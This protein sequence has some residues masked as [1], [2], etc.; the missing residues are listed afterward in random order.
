MHTVSEKESQTSGHFGPIKC[1][2]LDSHLH[3]MSQLGTRAGTLYKW[4]FSLSQGNALLVEAV[5]LWFESVYLNKASPFT[6]PQTGD[7]C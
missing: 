3:K 5:L 2:N 6:P 1:A 7:S 4:A